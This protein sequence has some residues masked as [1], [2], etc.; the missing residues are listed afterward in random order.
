MVDEVS[1]R[2]R[3][4]VK[5]S[6]SLLVWLCEPLAKKY[7]GSLNAILH[8][9]CSQYLIIQDGISHCGEDLYK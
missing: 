7:R 3:A 5:G 6:Q 2:I 8:V 1:S 9:L 4:K